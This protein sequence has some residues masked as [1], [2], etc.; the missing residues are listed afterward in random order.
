MEGGSMFLNPS[1]MHYDDLKRELLQFP[2]SEHDDMVDALA[3][4]VL[5]IRNKNKFIAY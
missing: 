3:Y 1:N 4:G 5:E 2:E